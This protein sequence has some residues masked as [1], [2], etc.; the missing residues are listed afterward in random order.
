MLVCIPAQK[1]GKLVAAL[2]RRQIRQRFEPT[3][4]L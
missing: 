2:L 3:T 4:K 1:G